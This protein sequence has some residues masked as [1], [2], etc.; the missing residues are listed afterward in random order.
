MSIE[1]KY[2]INLAL[3]IHPVLKGLIPEQ[4]PQLFCSSLSFTHSFL[5]IEDVLI[6]YPLFLIHFF[7]WWNSSLGYICGST[8]YLHVYLYQ[9][10]CST[11]SFA[12]GIQQLSISACR[13][14]FVPWKDWIV[15]LSK[16]RKK[17]HKT[18]FFVRGK[19][20]AQDSSESPSPTGV[21]DDTIHH[22]HPTFQWCFSS[23]IYI[24]M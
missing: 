7:C 14:V 17:K 12:V 23:K 19:Q 13:S 24:Y 20:T 1:G 22:I 10:S 6:F 15:L 18:R 21:I 3:K 8:A 2:V 9:H 16:R 4:M 5:W 11:S